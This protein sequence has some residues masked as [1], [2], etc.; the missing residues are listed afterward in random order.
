LS[1]QLPDQRSGALVTNRPEE[2]FGP[3]KPSLSLL[4][5]YIESRPAMPS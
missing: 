1:S 4:S 3:K 2:Q 5:L